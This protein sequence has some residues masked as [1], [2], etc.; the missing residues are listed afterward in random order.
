MRKGQ[1][2][3]PA[4][5]FRMTVKLHLSCCKKHYKIYIYKVFLELSFHINI[6]QISF[7]NVMKGDF[8]KLCIVTGTSFLKDYIK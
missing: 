4:A 7:G 2:F 3:E 6:Y 8:G 1:N 5:V